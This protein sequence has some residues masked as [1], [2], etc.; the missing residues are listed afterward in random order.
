MSLALLEISCFLIEVSLKSNKKC[1]T[2]AKI[3]NLVVFELKLQLYLTITDT[4]QQHVQ[5]VYVKG[6]LEL[7]ECLSYMYDPFMLVGQH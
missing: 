1:K 3:Q 4:L 5:C 7:L 6:L 2:Q